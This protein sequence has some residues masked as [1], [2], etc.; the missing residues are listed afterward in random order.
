MSETGGPAAQPPRAGDEFMIVTGMSGAGRTTVA[1]VM[2]D[3]GW[4]VVDNLPPRLILDL[5]GLAREARAA[6]KTGRPTRVAAVVDVRARGF[7][8]SLSEAVAELVSQGWEPNILFLDATDE[9]LVRRFES[10]RRPHPLQGD[11]RLLDGIHAE[12]EL[13]ED[14]RGIASVVIDTSGLNVHQLTRKVTPLVSQSNTARLR[15]AVLSF[16][17]K[18]GVPLDAD[19]V[20]DLRFLPNPFWIPELRNLTGLDSAVADFVAAQPGATQFVEQAATM[21]STVAEGYLREGRR[22]ATVAVGCT[23]GKHRS[24]AIAKRLAD[25]L[26]IEDAA[27]FTLHR[28]LGRE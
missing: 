12:R 11:G 1:D 23:G 15:L 18:Y 17:F 19:F 14:L 7:Q 4:Y 21:L 24:V 10:V 9:T 6:S 27:T 28:D 5:V 25:A 13:L 26:T 16:G 22:Y 3:D 20:F 8:V 2:E